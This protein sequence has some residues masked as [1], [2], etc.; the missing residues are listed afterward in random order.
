MGTIVKERS[1][2]AHET[3]QTRLELQLRSRK[4]LSLPSEVVYMYLGREGRGQG[5][6]DDSKHRGPV[7]QQGSKRLEEAHRALWPRMGRGEQPPPSIGF[8]ATGQTWSLRLSE[9]SYR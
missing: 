4:S 3:V 7:Q 6:P 5:T 1:L 2:R 8:P 9:S